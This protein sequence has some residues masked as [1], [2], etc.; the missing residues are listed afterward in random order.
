MTYEWDEQ[1]RLLNLEIHKVDFSVIERFEW[2]SA[3]VKPDQRRNYGELRFQAYG[4]INNRLYCLVFTPRGDHIRIISLRKA[5][6]R[7]VQQ[8]VSKT[9]SAN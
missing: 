6:Q 3:L 9:D 7:E 2:S 8:Y 5:N 1:K 4:V